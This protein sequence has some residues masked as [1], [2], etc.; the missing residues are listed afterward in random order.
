MKNLLKKY[1]SKTEKRAMIDIFPSSK[2]LKWK[3]WTK[4]KNELDDW[5][6]LSVLDI[7]KTNNNNNDKNNI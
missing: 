5:E 2:I 3:D 1:K 7:S 6:E 4:N